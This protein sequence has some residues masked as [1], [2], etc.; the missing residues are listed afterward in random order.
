MKITELISILQEAHKDHGEIEV[1]AWSLE[2]REFA[3]V[4]DTYIEDKA[5]VLDANGF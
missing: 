4:V 2:L 1:K 5:M 3:P